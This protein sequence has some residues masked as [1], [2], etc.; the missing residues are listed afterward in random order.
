M[1]TSFL[2][3]GRWSSALV[4][5]A[6]LASLVPLP[7]VADNRVAIGTALVHPGSTENSAVIERLMSAAASHLNARYADFL[8]AEVAATGAADFSV[9][10]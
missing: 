8:S 4:V 2:A 3:S 7:A 6:T 9:A 5:C 10:R 1:R